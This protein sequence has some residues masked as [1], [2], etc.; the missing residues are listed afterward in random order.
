MKT[1]KS[2]AAVRKFGSRLVCVKSTATAKTSK[3]RDA[4]REL[5]TAIRKV[6]QPL[7]VMF[8]CSEVAAR[9]V[10]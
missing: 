3:N 2:D 4:R 9:K 7:S 8:F 10:D 6:V 5:A 1:Y